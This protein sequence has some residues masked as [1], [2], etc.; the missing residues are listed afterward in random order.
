MMHALPTM[1]RSF[2]RRAP[3]APTEPSELAASASQ[4][5]ELLPQGSEP[6]DAASVGAYGLSPQ[7]SHRSSSAAQL[8]SIS[9]VVGAGVEPSSRSAPNLAAQQA[10][11]PRSSVSFG[12]RGWPARPGGAQPLQ[13]SPSRLS[14]SPGVSRTPQ[15]DLGLASDAAE[16][17][18]AAA[19]GSGADTPS[20]LPC[21]LSPSAAAIAAAAAA[22]AQP[23]LRRSLASHRDTMASSVPGSFSFAAP[24]RRGMW[25]GVDGRCS[26]SSLPM[27]AA[28]HLSRH[29]CLLTP[30]AWHAH[31]Q[32][33]AHQRS[34]GS[35]A[36]GGGRA[37]RRARDGRASLATLIDL[38][39]SPRELRKQSRRRTSIVQ[40]RRERVG[41]IGWWGGGRGG[42]SEA[43]RVPCPPASARLPSPTAPCPPRLHSYP[44]PPHIAHHP[45]PTYSPAAA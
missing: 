33:P 20:L 22:A 27:I 8:T 26:G 3:L 4:E 30:T 38:G 37:S 11:L 34:L 36:S 44:P 17:A 19:A 14:R 1:V 10:P 23:E 35:A 31:P 7:K 6:S 9:V 42:G 18:A 41:W 2:S 24:V 21:Q 39:T 29:P 45:R 13:L 40:V 28:G 43:Q 12:P 16:A 5:G 32:A 25:C 15:A